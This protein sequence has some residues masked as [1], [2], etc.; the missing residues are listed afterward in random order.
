MPQ[1]ICSLQVW[2]STA[3]ATEVVI[4]PW[5]F[6]GFSELLYAGIFSSKQHTVIPAKELMIQHLLVLQ[7]NCFGAGLLL[8]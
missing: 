6:P 8:Q 5:G 7:E 2:F 1:Y 4:L 3:A